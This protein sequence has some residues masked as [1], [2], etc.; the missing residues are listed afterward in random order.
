MNPTER[1][2]F[3]AYSA[4]LKFRRAKSIDNAR[5]VELT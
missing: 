1:E 2:A 3:L 5:A 4:L